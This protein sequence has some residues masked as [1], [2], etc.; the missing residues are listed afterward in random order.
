MGMLVNVLRATSRD[1]TNGGLSSRFNTL[2]VMNAHGPF[3][4]NEHTPPVV[5]R[6][7]AYGSIHIV[8][9]TV[10][11]VA[12]AGHFMAGG[13]YAGSSDG[14]FTNAVEAMLG[15]NFYGAVAIHDRKE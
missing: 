9:A 11:G 5:L 13:N 7:G 10:E 12:E 2:C 1:C 3:M 8:P 14:R 4:P 6:K 15:H